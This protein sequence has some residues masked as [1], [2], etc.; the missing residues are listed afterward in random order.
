MEEI[1]GF[2]LKSASQEQVTAA[3]QQALTMPSWPAAGSV[4]DAGEYVIVKLSEDQ[5]PEEVLSASAEATNAPEITNNLQ[6]AVDS[7]NMVDDKLQIKGWIIREGVNA[8]MALPSVYLRSRTTGEY[9]R[10]STARVARPDLVNAFENG[11]LYENA[12]YA[13]AVT[14]STLK[15]S[16]ENYDLLIGFTTEENADCAAETGYQWPAEVLGGGEINE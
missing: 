13:A 6:I 8:D 12:G 14:P 7:V 10:I 1:L 9:L 3:R 4:V 2:S 11:Y 15:E 5:W 16:L